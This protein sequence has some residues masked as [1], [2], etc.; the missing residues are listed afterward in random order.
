MFSISW[1]LWCKTTC[2]L[3]LTMHNLTISSCTIA[4]T[5]SQ[6]YRNDNF[7]ENKLWEPNN[8]LCCEFWYYYCCFCNTH[9]FIQSCM[10]LLQHSACYW[11]ILLFE[12]RRIKCVIIFQV[13]GIVRDIHFVRLSIA[14][15]RIQIFQLK[16]TVV[17]SYALEVCAIALKVTLDSQYNFI[18]FII[19]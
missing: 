17:A 14:S 5:T 6:W 9:S 4:H 18:S 12:R 11:F 8:L 1:S 7:F 2:F 19:V 10:H 13:Y 16:K 3:F 15:D